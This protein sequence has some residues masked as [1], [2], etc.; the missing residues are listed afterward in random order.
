MDS[1]LH[2]SVRSSNKL[3]IINYGSVQKLRDRSRVRHIA[4]YLS[5]LGPWRFRISDWQADLAGL[6]QSRNNDHGSD[7]TFVLGG[8]NAFSRF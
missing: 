1:P 6:T 2:F 8:G 3:V 7:M 4:V 5:D